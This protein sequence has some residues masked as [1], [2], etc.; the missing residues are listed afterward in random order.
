[1]QRIRITQLC[2]KSVQASRFFVLNRSLR[3][4]PRPSGTGA[5]FLFLSTGAEASAYYRSASP[6]RR[7][8]SSP[9]IHPASRVPV[10]SVL[11]ALNTYKRRPRRKIGF[12]Q[13]QT[14]CWF[15]ARDCER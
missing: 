10:M 15:A 14:G 1:G 2:E 13:T 12:K 9:V 3:A 11:K 8:F 4:S 7:R 6:R 5:L